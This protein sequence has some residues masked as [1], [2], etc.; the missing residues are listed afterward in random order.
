L[1]I[2]SI[3]TRYTHLN[4]HITV[5]MIIGAVFRQFCMF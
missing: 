2:D 4:A 3:I 1:A 5:F